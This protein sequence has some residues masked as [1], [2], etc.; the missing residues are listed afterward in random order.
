MDSICRGCE[1]IIA[2]YAFAFDFIVFGMEGFN[3]IVGIDWLAHFRAIIDCEKCH[4][5]LTMPKGDTMYY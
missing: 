3:I 2:N 5:T 4:I 1:L